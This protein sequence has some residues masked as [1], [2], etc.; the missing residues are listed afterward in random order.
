MITI[1]QDLG[2]IGVPIVISWKQGHKNMV[3]KKSSQVAAA[4]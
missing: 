3:N 1:N 2:Q 4:P